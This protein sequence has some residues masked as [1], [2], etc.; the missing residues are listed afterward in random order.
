[1]E[2]VIPGTVDCLPEAFH[3]LWGWSSFFN[4]PLPFSVSSVTSVFSWH[5]AFLSVL[6]VLSVISVTSVFNPQP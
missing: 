1:M 4:H 6:S 2:M 3:A 5:F